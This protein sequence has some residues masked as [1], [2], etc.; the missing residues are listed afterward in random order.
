MGQMSGKLRRTVRGYA[1][2]CP[3]CQEMHV[4]FDS[5]SFNGDLN[6]PT[7]SPSVKI[8]ERLTVKKDGRWTG[9]WVRDANGNAVD[10][11]CHYI[12]A[13]GIIHYCGDCTHAL[14]GKQLPLPLL[15]E[16]LRD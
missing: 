13:S 15:P 16:F 5:W 2:W 8:G 14:A 12:L 4:I 10:Q 1:H 3:A 6:A 11:C 9:E 7:F